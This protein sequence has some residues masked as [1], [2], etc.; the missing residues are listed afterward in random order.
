MHSRVVLQ[1]KFVLPHCC[2]FHFFYPIFLYFVSFSFF[3][4]C[5]IILCI[6]YLDSQYLHA[7][8]HE[9][10]FSGFLPKFHWFV[11]GLWELLFLQ[12]VHSPCAN[13]PCSMFLQFPQRNTCVTAALMVNFPDCKAQAA[14]VWSDYMHLHLSC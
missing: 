4:L 7:P 6:L 12:Q 13:H 5:I 2:H 1:V 11:I 14:P 3:A 9:N 8:F 10:T